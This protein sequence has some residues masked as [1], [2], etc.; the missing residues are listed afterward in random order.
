MVKRAAAI[1]LL[2]VLAIGC[3]APP[4]SPVYFSGEF[5]VTGS[6]SVTHANIY[7]RAFGG[8]SVAVLYNV[9][10]PWSHSFDGVQTGDEFFLAAQSNDDATTG[11]TI[12]VLV[13][14]GVGASVV[15]T[16]STAEPF[17]DVAVYGQVP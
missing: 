6:G 11:L 2:V 13:D 4:A 14:E 5:R 9:V 12:D 7:Y 8:A 15:A 17:G 10:L 1:A 16:D 3:Q